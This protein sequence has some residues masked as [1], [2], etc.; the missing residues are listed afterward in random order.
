MHSRTKNRLLPSSPATATGMTRAVQVGLRRP[1]PDRFKANEEPSLDDL[2]A[3][4]LTHTLM[5]SDGLPGD[6]VLAAIEQARAR[7]SGGAAD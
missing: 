5:A 3:D 2:L 1:Q 7:L 4:P 6:A